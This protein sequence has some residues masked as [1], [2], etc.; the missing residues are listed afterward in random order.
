MNHLLI[1]NLPKWPQMV[2]T[3]TKITK[4]QALEIIRRTDQFLGFPMGNDRAF[5]EK[6]KKTL[7]IPEGYSEQA[8]WLEDWGYI[9]TEYVVNDWICSDFID[10]AYGWCHPDG[11]IG[12]AYNIGKWPSVSEVLKEWETLAAAFPFLEVEATLMSAEYGEVGFP[13]V[14]FLIR[15]GSVELV[16][17]AQRNIHKEFDRMAPKTNDHNDLFVRISMGD[18]SL[19]EKIP[20]EIIEGWAKAGKE[21]T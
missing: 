12:Y 9:W 13:V 20:I 15:N 11:T 4:E 18:Y 10:G 7:K 8:K 14:S 1:A 6:V 5:S 19:G 3:G 17:P 2:V 16:D 21:K